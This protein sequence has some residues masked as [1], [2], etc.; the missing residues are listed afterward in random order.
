[1]KGG[2][3]ARQ[4]CGSRLSAMNSLNTVGLPHPWEAA[5]APGDRRESR[6]RKEKHHKAP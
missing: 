1:M 5:C 6:L 2:Q 4:D 3:G